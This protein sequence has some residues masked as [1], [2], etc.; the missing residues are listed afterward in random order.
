MH[1]TIFSPGDWNECLC[2]SGVSLQTYLPDV[3][4]LLDLDEL[5]SL[6][7]KPCFEFVLRANYEHYLQA[8]MWRLLRS[9]LLPPRFSFP[10]HSDHLWDLFELCSFLNKCVISVRWLQFFDLPKIQLW[11]I[12]IYWPLVTFLKLCFRTT[13]TK[14]TKFIKDVTLKRTDFWC[15]NTW[16]LSI[17]ELIVN[18]KYTFVFEFSSI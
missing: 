17:C 8:Q 13:L 15:C 14:C 10:L 3:K 16:N 2:V 4:E 5:S 12:V 1:N 11:F 6:K 9:S 7:S 18:T